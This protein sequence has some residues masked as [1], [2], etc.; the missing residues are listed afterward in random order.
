MHFPLLVILS[1]SVLVLRSQLTSDGPKSMEPNLEA[2]TALLSALGAPF[3]P[4]DI[5]VESEPSLEER[6]ATTLHELPV[7]R[8]NH[9]PRHA[10]PFYG[11]A[12]PMG[13]PMPAYSFCC[14]FIAAGQV[15]VARCSAYSSA[16]SSELHI[17]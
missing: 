17:I 6:R 13:S 12:S 9:Q 15:L 11:C 3:P 8:S 2:Q 10:R 1:G 4:H 14:L 7:R 16:R 5:E